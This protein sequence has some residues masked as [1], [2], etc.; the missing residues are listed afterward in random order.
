MDCSKNAPEIEVAPCSIC[1]NELIFK[2]TKLKLYLVC[3][4]AIPTICCGLGLKTAPK[5]PKKGLW[6]QYKYACTAENGT[7]NYHFA[8]GG[9]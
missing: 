1:G 6:G 4:R 8:P 7:E 5:G 9:K 3:L 2:C